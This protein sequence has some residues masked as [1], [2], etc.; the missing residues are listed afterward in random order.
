MFFSLGIACLSQSN[1][2]LDRDFLL[3]YGQFLNNKNCGII[4][5]IMPYNTTELNKLL[6]ED[7][8]VIYKDLLF[9]NNTP[10]IG[11]NTNTYFNAYPLLGGDAAYDQHGLKSTYDY[12]AGVHLDG[13]IG[14]KLSYS[15]NYAGGFMIAPSFMDS[16]I[17]KYKVIPGMGLAYGSAREGYSYQYWDG[18]ISWSPDQIFNFQVGKGKQFWGDGYRSL[19]LSDVSNSYPYFKISTSI[20]RIEYINLFAVMQDIESSNGI[21]GNFITTYSDFHYLSWDV[22]KRVNISFYE[23]ITYTGNTGDTVRSFD[24]NYL[25]PAIFY[26]P[27]NFNNGD[28][29]KSNLGAAF[30]LKVARNGQFYGQ[31]LID[32]FVLHNV[33]SHTEW[34]GNKQGVQGGFKEFNLFKVAGLTFQTEINYIRPYTYSADITEDSYSNFGQP[35][36]DPEGANFIE[37]ASF[38]SWYH[39][40]LEIQGSLVFYRYGADS[41]KKDFGQNL[42]IPY[43]ERAYQFGVITGQG[44]PV[45]L[46]VAGL[47]ADEIISSKMLLKAELG[48]ELRAE[49]VASN[50]VETYPYIYFG[51]K[52][53]LGNLYNDF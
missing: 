12:F 47:R 10:L 25:N 4:T 45:Y 24:I 48:F 37:S 29:D 51:I 49:R 17:K 46:A 2:T 6:Q 32:E 16:I 27:V 20:W 21:K 40:N 52:T 31:V 3:P 19:F 8:S 26:Q 44:V 5:S 39:K 41:G 22:S 36:A 35:L 11:N 38:L 14:R 50:A 53:S 30:R 18:Y 23:A 7:S 42:F 13:N 34:W 33:I 43:E 15:L 9:K 1:F 28:P